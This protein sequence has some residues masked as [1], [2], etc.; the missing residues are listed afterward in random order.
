[1]AREYAA[2]VAGSDAGTVLGDV[3]TLQDQLAAPGKQ[4][5]R[6]NVKVFARFRP[7]SR[8]ETTEGGRYCVEFDDNKQT[9]VLYG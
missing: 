3:A 7:Q 5:G 6:D 2:S 4:K 9:L 1:M 8:K